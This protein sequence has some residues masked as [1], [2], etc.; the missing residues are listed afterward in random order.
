MPDE[1]T[2]EAGDDEIGRPVPRNVPK[3]T[4]VVGADAPAQP[5]APAP[6]NVNGTLDVPSA[7]ALLQLL[8]PE[9]DDKI[10]ETIGRVLHEQMLGLNAR[11]RKAVA[12]VVREAVASAIAQ[13]THASDVR[14]NP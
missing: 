14:D 3:L 12:E 4:D 5:S 6:G 11:V 8:G 7:E 1:P 9:L 10:S 2:P 13:Q